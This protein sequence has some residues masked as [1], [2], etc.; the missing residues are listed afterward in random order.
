MPVRIPLLSKTACT[1]LRCCG[2]L[3]SV[4]PNNLSRITRK[5]FHYQ[6]DSSD[7]YVRWWLGHGT[8]TGKHFHIDVAAPGYFSDET[9]EIDSQEE[10]FQ[11]A[12]EL[13]V[14]NQIGVRVSG[15]FELASDKLPPLVSALNSFTIDRE[16]VNAKLTEGELKLTGSVVDTVHWKSSLE[17]HGNRIVTLRIDFSTSAI[18]NTNYIASLFALTLK[19]MDSLKTL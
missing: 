2:E 11:R 13:L 1:Y 7:V 5:T 9:P 6:E 10:E 17:A 18:I 15:T 19:A 4:D 16:K 12:V 14:G 3:K 8:E